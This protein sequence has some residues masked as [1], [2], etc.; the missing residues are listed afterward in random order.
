MNEKV[1]GQ[2]M[3]VKRGATHF[4]I[5]IFVTLII[6]FSFE[7]PPSYAT[8]PAIAQDI[9]RHNPKGPIFIGVNVRGEYTSLQHER[10]PNSVFPKDYY[11]DSFSLIRDAG[12][13][14]RSE[15]EN[16]D[17]SR[18]PIDRPLELL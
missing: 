3:F 16:E 1:L 18:F 15:Y 9:D 8:P 7:N 11:D 6:T 12:D 2:L 17:R 13:C 10:Y 5:A 14:N 4:V